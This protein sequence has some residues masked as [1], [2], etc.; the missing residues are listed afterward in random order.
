M[1]KAAT[2]NYISQ[3]YQDRIEISL[4]NI[5]RG[6]EDKFAI[7]GI[8]YIPATFKCELCGHE[9]C[10]YAYTVRNLETDIDKVVGSECVKHFKDKGCNIDVAAGLRKRVKSVTR[11]MRRYMKKYLEEDQYKDMTV[12]KKRELTIRLFMKHQAM[13]ALKAQAGDTKKSLLKKEDVL[14]V[15][16]DCPE[17]EARER[18]SKKA[19][20]SKKNSPL[21][22]AESEVKALVEK[23]TNEGLSDAE[24]KALKNAQER[25]RYYKN[26]AA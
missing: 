19:K 14:R 5:S 20:R 22:K 8:K 24:K 2:G 12:E 7:V 21:N 3:A 25:V 11:K 17:I 15:I 13:E 23:R 10:L 4:G 9:P 18:K 6:P 16:D 1:G 26:K